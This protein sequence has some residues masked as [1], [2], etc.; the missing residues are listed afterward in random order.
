MMDDPASPVTVSGQSTNSRTIHARIP[1]GVRDGQR[2]RLK[3]K[4]SPGEAA[5]PMAICT[6]SS[7]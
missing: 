5:V 7:T 3:G 4:G 2:I 6:S 1:A